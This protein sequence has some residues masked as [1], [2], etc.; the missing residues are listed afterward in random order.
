M[1]LLGLSSNGRSQTSSE[2]YVDSLN[3]LSYDLGSSAPSKAIRIAE[4]AKNRA[5]SIKYHDGVTTS[6]LRIGMAYELQGKLNRAL[7]K[8]MEAEDYFN[9][10]GGDSLML[11]KVF[12]YQ[13]TLSKS[14]GEFSQAI[15]LNRRAFAIARRKKDK[16][17]MGYALINTSNIYKDQGEYAKGL[18][19]LHDA[20]KTFGENDYLEKG[21]IFLNTGNIYEL[22]GRPLEAIAFFQ[23]AARNYQLAKDD[24]SLTKSH[25]NL[26][27]AYL[28]VDQLDSALYHYNLAEQI[29]ADR[30]TG[31]HALIFQNKG[32]LFYRTNQLDSALVYFERSIAMGEEGNDIESKMTALMNIGNIQVDKGQFRESVVSY[33][34]SYEFAQSMNDLQYLRMISA[35]LSEVYT[36]LGDLTKAN[37]YLHRAQN[38]QDSISDRLKESL[39]YEMNYK[40]Q[41]H[42]ISQL[43]LEVENKNLLLKK[44]SDFLWLL[45]IIVFITFVTLVLL[46]MN[47]KNKRK[48]LS[49]EKE[50]IETEQRMKELINNQ[51]KAELNAKFDGQESERNRISKE[52][53]DNLGSMLSTVKLYFK[54]I[55]SQIDQLKNENVIKYEKATS[56]LDEACD[57]TRRIAHQLSSKRLWDVG[58]FATVRTLQHQIND[59]D[60]LV[61]ELHTHGDDARLDRNVQNSIYRI[62][63]ELLQ[64]INKHANAKRVEIQLNVFDDLFNLVVED[65]GVGF[66]V[67]NLLNKGGIGLREIEYRVKTM[68]G[69]LTIDSGRGAGTNTTIDI[70]LNEK[71]D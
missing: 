38:Y 21:D 27:N 42:Q 59:S 25:I 53:H 43:E 6:L 67:N 40:D 52:I 12:I 11:A 61:V 33:L 50:T 56:L 34:K 2:H 15:A 13:G 8:Y 36:E 63:Q 48:R 51:E 16:A 45:A 9:H 62:I 71:D 65:D 26:G 54:A 70:P 60:Q 23:S 5:V 49:A 7:A 55:D 4:K 3:D 58:L 68:S 30:F 10:N 29:S 1:I 22:Q 37:N 66:D 69:E 46:Y 28:S 41:Q 64:N 32:A 14:R 31:L 24:F 44:Q 19:V 18:K 39:I 20:V 17:L 47:S 35:K 57:E